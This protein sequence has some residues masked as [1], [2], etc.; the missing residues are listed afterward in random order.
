MRH[1]RGGRRGVP[2]EGEREGSRGV[3]REVG[4][5]KEWKEGREDEGEG[6]GRG[7]PCEGSVFNESARTAATNS[8][9]AH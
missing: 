5:G 9:P 7:V 2:C 1:D 8:A 3:G 6:V 4:C